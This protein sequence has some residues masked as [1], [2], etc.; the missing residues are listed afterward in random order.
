MISFDPGSQRLV[1]HSVTTSVS[2]TFGIKCHTSNPHVFLHL[3]IVTA[4][5]SFSERLANPTTFGLGIF[6]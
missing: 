2:I 4:V 3:F 1:N 6:Y 5:F